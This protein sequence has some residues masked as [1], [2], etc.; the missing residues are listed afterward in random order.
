MKIINLIH[1]CLFV[2]LGMFYADMV[3]AGAKNYMQQQSNSGV[4]DLGE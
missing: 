3:T 1:C 2:I 4:T